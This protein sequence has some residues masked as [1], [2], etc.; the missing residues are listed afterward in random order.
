MKGRDIVSISDLNKE[1]ILSILERAQIMKSGDREPVLKG[2][3]LASCF[4]EPST[5]TRLSFEAAMKRLGGDVIGFSD[6]ATTSSQ[7]GETLHDTMKVLGSY[8]DIIVIRHPTSGSAKEAAQATET[9]VINGGDG[10]NEHPTQTLLDLFTIR[11]CQGRMDGLKVA[12]VG[13]L[14]N[15]RTVHSLAPALGLFDNR[16]Y[17]VSP[18][19][20]AMP[21]KICQH[22]RKNGVLFSHHHAIEDVID[23]AD[24]LFMTRVQQERFTNIQEFHQVR[25]HFILTPQILKK[26]KTNLKVLHPLPRVNEIEKTVDTTPYAYYFPQAQNGL[27]VRQALLAMLLGK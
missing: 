5:R 19:S 3:L 22:L 14:L 16:L 24:I 1:E 7:K 9:P 12:F 6:G 4:F 13:D 27:W 2:H 20:L 26:G 23:K 11:E 17:F 18:P 15:G 25:D 8:C 21:E 10:A